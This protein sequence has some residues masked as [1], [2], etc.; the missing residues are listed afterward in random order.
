M[1][2]KISNG[3]LPLAQGVSGR[4]VL[5]QELLEIGRAGLGDFAFLIVRAGLIVEMTRT[6]DV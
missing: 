4:E 3:L 5:L 2:L 1:K 6:S